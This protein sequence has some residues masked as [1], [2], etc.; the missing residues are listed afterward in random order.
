MVPWDP[1]GVPR[2]PILGPTRGIFS[3]LNGPCPLGSV[4][5]SHTSFS[6]GEFR[7]A[8]RTLGSD[9]I[10]SLKPALDGKTRFFNASVSSAL[11][12]DSSGNSNLLATGEMTDKDSALVPCYSPIDV[13]TLSSQKD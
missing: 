2:V 8:Q 12:G 3:K 5:Q 7:A 9:V 1:L 6:T 13:N 4:D 10:C 11:Q